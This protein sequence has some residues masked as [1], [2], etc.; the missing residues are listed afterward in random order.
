MTAMIHG[1]LKARGFA[2]RTVFPPRSSPRLFTQEANLSYPMG[3]EIE[4]LG[5]V[6]VPRDKVVRENKDA[7]S[8]D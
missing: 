3:Y 1:G 5:P 6:D 4:R 7:K 2:I 8:G